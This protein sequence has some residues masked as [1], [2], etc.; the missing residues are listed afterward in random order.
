MSSESSPLLDK[1]SSINA[2]RSNDDEAKSL[3]QVLADI[4][5]GRVHVGPVLIYTLIA[6]IGSFMFGYVLG[7]SSLTQISLS[8]NATHSSHVD[9]HFKLTDDEF[10]YFGVSSGT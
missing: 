2:S 9:M 6:V 8:K 3:G 4:R 5:A 10:S 1:K 7:Y